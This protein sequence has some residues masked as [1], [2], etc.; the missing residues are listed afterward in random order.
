MK[1]DFNWK[2]LDVCGKI[3][4]RRSMSERGGK[5]LSA[6]MVLTKHLPT[7]PVEFEVTTVE[8]LA[9]LL[10]QVATEQAGGDRVQALKNLK[11]GLE[12]TR[13]IMETKTRPVS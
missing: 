7:G 5:Q 2:E 9:D 8:E 6:P 1:Q 11:S 13:C 10:V 4:T 3:C 12:G